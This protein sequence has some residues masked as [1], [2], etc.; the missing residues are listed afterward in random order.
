MDEISKITLQFIMENATTEI[1]LRWKLN[2]FIEKGDTSFLGT[3]KSK[4]LNQKIKEY[5]R[6]Q[7]N[8]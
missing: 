3:E 6:N 8:T 5:E 7:S 2:K 1:D 4:L